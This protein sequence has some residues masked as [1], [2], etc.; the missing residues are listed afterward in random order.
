MSDHIIVIIWV[1][2]VFFV[3]FFCVF[4]VDYTG[5]H[6]YLFSDK[7]AG[8][9]QNRNKKKE[10][11]WIQANLHLDPGFTTYFYTPLGKACRIACYL[12]KQENDAPPHRNFFKIL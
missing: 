11:L 12:W 6:Q 8:N 7:P 5:D 1:V 9:T 3:P 10:K 4:L 2:K